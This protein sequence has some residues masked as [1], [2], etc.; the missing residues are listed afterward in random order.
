MRVPHQGEFPADF[1][2]RRPMHCAEKPNAET[3]HR[4]VFALFWRV[5]GAHDQPIWKFALLGSSPP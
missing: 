1:L 3:D 4:R 2:K 5:V